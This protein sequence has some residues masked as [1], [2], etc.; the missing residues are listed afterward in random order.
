MCLCVCFSDGDPVTC[1]GWVY[2]CGMSDHK[3]DWM[4]RHATPK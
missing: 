4:L 2:S 1:C 3:I